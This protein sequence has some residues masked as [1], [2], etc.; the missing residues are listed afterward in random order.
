M[1][2]LRLIAILLV[3]LCLEP[4]FTESASPTASAAAPVAGQT[5]PPA[6]PAAPPAEAGS[7]KPS[8]GPDAA[9]VPPVQPGSVSATP[10]S[11]ALSPPAVSDGQVEVHVTLEP[12]EIPF[13][14]Q[15]KFSIRVEAPAGTDVKIPNMIDHFGGLTA[16]HVD[17]ENKAIKNGRQRLTETYTLDPIFVNTYRIDPVTVTWGNNQSLTVTSPALKVRDLTEE[18]KKA[19]EVFADNVEPLLL[20]NPFLR[21]YWYLVIGGFV[22]VLLASAVYYSFRMRHRRAILAPPLPP[23]ETAYALLRELDL[24]QLPQ[25]GLVET[26]YVELTGIL[27]RY[28]EDRFHLRAPEETTP[29]FLAEVA[30]ADLFDVEQQRVLSGFLRHCDRVKFARYEPTVNEMEKSFAFVLRFVD[31]TVPNLDHEP[32]ETKQNTVER[33]GA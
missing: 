28:I 15:S 4:G 26:Y 11:P 16:S 8:A 2:V 20:P 32:A 17:R 5:A 12:Q 19:A 10:S 6:L 30:R 24:Q 29:E 1:N 14:R 27:R 31:D 9:S 7:P 33:I 13:H 3:V 21:Y 23:W 18:E 25:Q 22:L